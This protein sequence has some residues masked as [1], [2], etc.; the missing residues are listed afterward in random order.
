MPLWLSAILILTHVLCFIGGVAVYH[1]MRVIAAKP[2]TMKPQKQIDP[3]TL[4]AMA[5]KIARK[6]AQEEVFKH[7]AGAP[8]PIHREEYIEDDGFGRS[9]ES[10]FAPAKR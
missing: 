7:M 9:R 3:A 2:L 1:H 6:Q 10:A 5:D 8:S 4:V